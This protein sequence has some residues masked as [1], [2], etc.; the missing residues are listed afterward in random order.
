MRVPHVHTFALERPMPD[1]TAASDA[2]RITGAAAAGAT[3]TALGQ[4]A[5]TV[6]DVERS[7][8]FYRDAV[9]LRF[10]FAAPPGLA[11]FDMGGVRL[12]LT[13]PEGRFT[14]GSGTVLYLRVSDIRAAHAAMS[15]RGVAFVDQPHL[16][17]PM[18]DHD[19]W[20]CF[21]RDPDGYT[22]GLMCERPK[23]SE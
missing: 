16:V 15:A 1:P 8:R 4:V 23:G 2:G 19:L 10:L 18:P 20:M 12:M 13:V 22:L 17:A 9:G 5:V 3:I 21:F 7:T 11:F 6:Q 14:P